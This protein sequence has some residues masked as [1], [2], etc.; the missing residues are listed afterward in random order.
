MLGVQYER[1]LRAGR[2]A[3]KPASRALDCAFMAACSPFYARLRLRDVA[4]AGRRHVAVETS[5]PRFESALA[6]TL[7]HPVVFLELLARHAAPALGRSRVY[8]RRRG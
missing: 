5:D 6:L 1:S 7:D 2:S 8:R 4:S 3:E